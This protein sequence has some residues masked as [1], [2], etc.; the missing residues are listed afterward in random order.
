[1]APSLLY[2]LYI[3]PLYVLLKPRVYQKQSLYPSQCRGNGTYTPP[4]PD[5]LVRLHWICCRRCFLLRRDKDKWWNFPNK[6]LKVDLQSLRKKIASPCT[7][8]S[9]SVSKNP[10]Q[11][12][13]GISIKTK[14]TYA[15]NPGSLHIQTRAY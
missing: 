10:T 13:I 12:E 15:L 6:L 4:S 8:S 7:L 5:P 3:L 9:H 11:N 14:K 2:F 1:M